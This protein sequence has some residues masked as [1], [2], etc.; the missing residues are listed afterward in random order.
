MS[1]MGFS[2]LLAVFRIKAD[3]SESKEER[4]VWLEAARLL[5]KKLKAHS[6]AERDRAKIN[7]MNWGWQVADSSVGEG[8][9]SVVIRYDNAND[10]FK[11]AAEAAADD[12]ADSLHLKSGYKE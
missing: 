10:I 2:T 6:D 1:Y 8:S 11:A 4:G 9:K 3:K 12:I 5:D 7:A